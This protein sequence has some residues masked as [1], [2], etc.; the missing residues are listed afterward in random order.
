MVG[1]DRYEGQAPC[2]RLSALY[3]P[4][5][6]YI[7]FFQPVMVLVSKERNGAKVKRRYDQAKTP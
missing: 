6:L 1:Y 3:E 5:R 7:N 2:D 4:L